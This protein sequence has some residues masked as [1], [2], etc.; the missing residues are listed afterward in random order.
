[1]SEGFY[2]TNEGTRTHV[3]ILTI[4]FTWILRTLDLHK[5]LFHRKKISLRAININ[6]HLVI[7]NLHGLRISQRES[8]L[9]VSRVH[10]SSCVFFLITI[11]EHCEIR[12]TGKQNIT[13][14][15]QYEAYEQK[16]HPETRDARIDGAHIESDAH[17]ST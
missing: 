8:T 4:D 7:S 6:E 9:V 15:P 10:F 5:S 14:K 2:R 3:E 11:S 1:V 13:T 17:A 16:P 12:Q